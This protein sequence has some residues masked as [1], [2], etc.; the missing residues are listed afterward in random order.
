MSCEPAGT[1][2]DPGQARGPVPTTN[3]F[4]AGMESPLSPA[5]VRPRGGGEHAGGVDEVLG[6]HALVRQMGF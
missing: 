2:R 1:G 6:R 4:R 5:A 3:R